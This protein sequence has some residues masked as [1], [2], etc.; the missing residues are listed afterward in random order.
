MPDFWDRILGGAPAPVR[1]QAP[2][3]A[4]WAPR[5]V[6][7]PM[8]PVPQEPAPPTAPPRQAQ[9]SRSTARCPNCS[10]G[11]YF[12]AN[13]ETKPRCYTCGYPVLHSTSGLMTDNK[14]SPPTRQTERSREGGYRP[15]EIVGRVR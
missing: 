15:S 13:P 7:A 2:L 5:P 6:P 11:D 4:W 1:D 3:D 14:P 10:S 8:P 12:R 9:S